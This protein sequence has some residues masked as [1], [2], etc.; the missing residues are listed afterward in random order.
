MKEKTQTVSVK[1]AIM[2]VYFRACKWFMAVLFLLIYALSVGASMAA[3]FWL[4]DWSD[5][6]GREGAG[7][8]NFSGTSMFTVCE[9]GNGPK[10]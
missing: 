10:V 7:S 6:E 5:A 9:D 3:G 4:A 2:L 8:V 1:L